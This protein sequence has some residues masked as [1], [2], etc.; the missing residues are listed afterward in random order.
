MGRHY[1]QDSTRNEKVIMSNSTFAKIE[2]SFKKAMRGEESCN[3]LIYY[4]GVIGYVIAYFIVNK[5]IL[6]LDYAFVD[7]VLA[8][9][10][11]IYFIWHIYALKKCSPKKPKLSKEERKQLRAERRKE[12]FRS[13]LRKLLLKEPITKFN[14][15]ST[16]IVFDLFAISNFVLYIF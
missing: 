15:V 1:L 7:A 13:F 10:A 14:P 5:T 16:T 3:I 12:F 8:I 4:W 2:D 11:I 6:A 9:L